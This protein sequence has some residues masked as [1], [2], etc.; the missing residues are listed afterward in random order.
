MRLPASMTALPPNAAEAPPPL[1]AMHVD[2][3]RVSDVEAE[4]RA[5]ECRPWWARAWGAMVGGA[6][7]NV[8]AALIAVMGAAYVGMYHAPWVKSLAGRAPATAQ[9]GEAVSVA[10]AA[11]PA[12][13]VP[14][15]PAAPMA[16]LEPSAQA[17][18]PERV[19]AARDRM[20]QRIYSQMPARARTVAETETIDESAPGLESHGRTSRDT[21]RHHRGARHLK[22]QGAPW[23]AAWY[24]GA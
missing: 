22:G 9:A 4:P 17:A 6:F 14:S 24:K 19:A 5:A 1:A 10:V 2:P 21:R 12:S 18:S 23:N 11:V 8:A 16:Q 20:E 7:T 3:T 13:A 15:R